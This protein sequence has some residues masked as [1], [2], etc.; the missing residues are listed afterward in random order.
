M[1]LS[2]RLGWLDNN[3]A[4]LCVEEKMREKL[5]KDGVDQYIVTF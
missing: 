5:E 3:G 4:V 1:A 2:F